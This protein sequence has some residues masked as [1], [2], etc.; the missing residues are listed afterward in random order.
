MQE[1]EQEIRRPACAP[2]LH[3]SSG[4]LNFA[5]R[6]NSVALKNFAAERNFVTAVLSLSLQLGEPLQS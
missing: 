5:A 3:C 6:R 1:W 4:N 2:L